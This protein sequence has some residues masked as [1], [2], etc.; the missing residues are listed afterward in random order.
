MAV[1]QPRRC[2]RQ[3]RFWALPDSLATTGGIILFIFFFLR[4]LECFQFPAFASHTGR[5]Y[6]FKDIGLSHSES[7]GQGPFA[8]H[9]GFSQ[10]ITSFIACR[11]RHPPC[12][13]HYFR[14]YCSSPIPPPVAMEKDVPFCYVRLH[15]PRSL[16][17]VLFV[18][19]SM[20]VLTH[21]KRANG[22][23]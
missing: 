12:A 17:Y 11:H 4:V 5:Q 20:T 9:R 21:P 23:E 16:F 8:P 22:G 15:I 6:L 7:A 2:R 3:R 13:L 10:L 1:L 14:L 19:M 18:N